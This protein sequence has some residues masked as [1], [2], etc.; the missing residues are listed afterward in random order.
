MRFNEG[1]H[2]VFSLLM[3]INPT[4]VFLSTVLQSVDGLPA[5]GHPEDVV[6]H[7]H[8]LL[9]QLGNEVASVPDL[10]RGQHDCLWSTESK[11]E[12]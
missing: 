7:I 3:T 6:L 9:F 11:N 12:P 10:W 5:N 4:A 8:D 1:T 2:G